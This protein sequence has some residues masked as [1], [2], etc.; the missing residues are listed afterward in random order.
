MVIPRA[1]SARCRSVSSFPGGTF[2]C[3]AG[4]QCSVRVV[5]LRDQHGVT[6]GNVGVR[7][8]SVPEFFCHG[9]VIASN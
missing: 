8:V 2:E 5:L 9:A 6:D 4:S 3:Q 7:L 1:L